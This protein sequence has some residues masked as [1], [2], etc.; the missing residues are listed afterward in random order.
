LLSILK[1]QSLKSGAICDRHLI[2]VSAAMQ[3]RESMTTVASHA[4]TESCGRRRQ[5]SPSKSRRQDPSKPGYFKA[6][7][8]RNHDQMTSID[9]AT[10]ATAGSARLFDIMGYFLIN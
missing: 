5:P 1:I 9:L 4:F 2:L 6:K 10:M 3:V 7:I 8:F